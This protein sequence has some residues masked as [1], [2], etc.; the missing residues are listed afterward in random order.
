MMTSIWPWRNNE[1][2]SQGNI[3]IQGNNNP[4][5]CSVIACI[6]DIT[7]MA[8]DRWSLAELMEKI[9]TDAKIR[10]MLNQQDLLRIKAHKLRWYTQKEN[11]MLKRNTR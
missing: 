11:L 4:Q 1:T 9:S 6:E 10:G 5:I 2:C 8:R 7:V 3:N